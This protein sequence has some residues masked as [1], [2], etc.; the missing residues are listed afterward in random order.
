MRPAFLTMAESRLTT[1]R[2]ASSRGD[3]WKIYGPLVAVVAI[4]FAVTF[5]TLDPPPPERFEIAAG[6]RTGAY[7]A[8]AERYQEALRADGYAL[9]IVETAGSVENLE[10]LNAGKIPL[11]LIQGGANAAAVDSD[12]RSLASLFYEPVWIF[13]RRDRATEQLREMTGRRLAVGAVGSGTRALV[14]PLLA[15]NGIDGDSAELLELDNST[16][17][18]ELEAGSVDAAFFVASPQAPFV[19]RLLANEDIELLPIVRSR[20]YRKDHPYLSR[21]VL[22]EGVVDLVHNLPDRDVPMLATT[23]SLVAAPELHDNIIPLLIEAAQEIHGTSGAFVDPGTFPSSEYVDFPINEVADRYLE[24]GPSFL[25][26]VLPHRTAATIDRLKILLLPFVTLLIPVLRLAP[27]IYRWRIRSRIY[28]WY[29]DLKWI[30]ESRRHDLSKEEL[31]E[32]VATIAE[33][34]QEVTDVSVPL[35]YMDEYYRLRNHV[36]LIHRK[37]ER[38]RSSV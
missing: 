5:A 8:F 29:E 27:P 26:R 1:R 18:V 7:H 28:R 6:G 23:A 17:V 22:G 36:E 10:L 11:A 35:S 4:A 21:V 13:Q 20:A 25:Y 19:A 24:R 34:E 2:Q 38:Q 14:L 12:L 15:A 3:W 9:E 33:L 31:D 30:D 16:A 32:L 37:L